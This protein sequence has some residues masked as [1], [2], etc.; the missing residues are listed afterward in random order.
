MLAAAK[1]ANMALMFL[2]ELGVL[3][4]AGYWGFTLDRHWALRLVAG[5]GAPALFVLAWALFGA[6][7]GANAIVPLTG[8]A[9]VVLEIVWFG[10][11]ALA[12]YGAGAALPAGVFAA[13]FVLNAVLRIVWKQV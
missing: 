10:G 12:L 3:V 4:S 5:I 13:L 6:G 7:G 1:Y 2:L 8:W 9:R 11:G